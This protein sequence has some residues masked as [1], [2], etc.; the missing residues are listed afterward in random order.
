MTA[1]P[2]PN[3]A[4]WLA[5]L[6]G[7]KKEARQLLFGGA[8]IEERGGIAPYLSTPLQIAVHQGWV[9]V[10]Q[11]LLEHGA[12]S[13]VIN[14]VGEHGGVMRDGGTPLHDARGHEAVALRLLQHGA[15]VS[16]RDNAGISPLD[17]AARRGQAGRV[18]DVRPVLA[19]QHGHPLLSSKIFL[20]DDSG[21]TALH[22]AALVGNDAVVQLLLEHR[23][24]VSAEDIHGRTPQDLAT[25]QGRSQVVAMFQAAAVT[26]AKCVAFAMGHHTRLGEGSLV[27]GLDPGVLRMVLEQV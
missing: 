10:V 24:S 19:Q 26:R 18:Q 1:A 27:E 4:L 11:L 2:A 12:D 7:Q 15:D 3:P 21:M 22:W 8:N 16:A 5:A 23:A 20:K 6:L 13:S 14:V 17:N 9:M 25:S